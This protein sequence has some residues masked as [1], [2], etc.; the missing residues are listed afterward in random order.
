MGHRSSVGAVIAAPA[1][2]ACTRCSRVVSLLIEVE[3]LDVLTYQELFVCERCAHELDRM[4][5][6]V[7]AHR[8][9]RV[10]GSRSSSRPRIVRGGIAV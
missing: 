2:Y 5:A 6:M 1:S 3:L 7:V 10:R 9:G 8:T 4:D